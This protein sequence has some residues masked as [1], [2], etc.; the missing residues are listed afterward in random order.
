MLPFDTSGIEGSAFFL[1]EPDL[2]LR[3]ETGGSAKSFE[4]PYNRL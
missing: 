3:H 2:L 4:A 1:R